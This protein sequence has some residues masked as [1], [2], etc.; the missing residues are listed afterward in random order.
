MSACIFR[1]TINLKV[2]VADEDLPLPHKRPASKELLFHRPNGIA[3]NIHGVRNV[4]GVA[5]A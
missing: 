4:F 1:L 5:P 2:P 3:M